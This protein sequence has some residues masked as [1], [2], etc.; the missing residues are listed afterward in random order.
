MTEYNK[1]PYCIVVPSYDKR[2]GLSF[3]S[4]MGERVYQE[5]PEEER[6]ETPFV[7]SNEVL[8]NDGTFK[9]QIKDSVRG[10]N[11]YVVNEPSINPNESLIEILMIIDA[12][13]RS[14][15]HDI[16]VFET[17]IPFL[18]QDKASGREPITSRLLGDM[19]LAAGANRVMTFHPHVDQSVMAFSSDCPLEA[20]PTYKY[21]ADCFRKDN[22]GLEDTVVCAPD[23]GA[24]KMVK[25]F[26]TY[27]GLP[28]TIINKE[29]T[30]VDTTRVEQLI[31]NVNGRRGYADHL[32]ALSGRRP[33]PGIWC[34]G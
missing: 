33:E 29:R 13:R 15:V 4:K 34:A 24:V 30:G 10:R 26:A 28:M 16:V 19:Y 20:F 2:R 18:R 14:D 1:Y 9:P 31:G 6:R 8:F 5:L 32:P 21:I 22:G 3:P 7:Y 23:L 17:Y 27:L 25:K 12:L 11:V